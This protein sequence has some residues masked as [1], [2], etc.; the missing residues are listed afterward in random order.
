MKVQVKHFQGDWHNSMLQGQTCSD[1]EQLCYGAVA[2][3][4]RDVAS[5]AIKGQLTVCVAAAERLETRK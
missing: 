1:G 3:L 4:L 2:A 5:G